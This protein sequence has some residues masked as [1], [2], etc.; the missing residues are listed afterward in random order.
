MELIQTLMYIALFT[1]LLFLVK[2]RVKVL[3]AISGVDLEKAMRV[4]LYVINNYDVDGDGTMSAEEALLLIAGI[5]NIL[6][7]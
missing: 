1:A 4:Y 6:K 2:Y 3:G 5:R 7:R